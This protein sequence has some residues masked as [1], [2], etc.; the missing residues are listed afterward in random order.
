MFQQ[1]LSRIPNWLLDL[2]VIVFLL[3]I[4]ILA[5]SPTMVFGTI[6]CKMQDGN[7][8]SKM[9]VSVNF[10]GHDVRTN[11]A[12]GTGMFYAPVVSKIGDQVAD[13]YVR[14]DEIDFRIKEPVE[15]D[16]ASIWGARIFRVSVS[17]FERGMFT[18]PQ[19]KR[20]GGNW[21]YSVISYLSLSAEANAQEVMTFDAY[22]EFK[23][24]LQTSDNSEFKS[25]LPSAN[26]SVAEQQIVEG[27]VLSAAQA[28]SQWKASSTIESFDMRKL[29]IDDISAFNLIV[30]EK[31]GL[32]IAPENWQYIENGADATIHL[33]SLKLLGADPSTGFVSMGDTPSWSVFERAYMDKTGKSLV[34]V[35]N[36]LDAN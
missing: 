31:S 32:T 15:F 10:S 13:I 11:V 33:K 36:V 14:I 20:H 3:L 23:A 28:T 5:L 26:V 17:E 29:S 9:S 8:C 1:I 34:V 12:D 18:K 16:M 27:A 4:S 6:D 2:A 30:A 22:K 7:R 19:L 25:L 21:L 24:K 35:P